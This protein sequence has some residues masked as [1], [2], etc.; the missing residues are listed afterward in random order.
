MWRR[1]ATQETSVVRLH[2]RV[3][4]GPPLV[5]T[6]RRTVMPT[7]EIHMALWAAM[8]DPMVDPERDL[9]P[10]AGAVHVKR[11]GHPLQ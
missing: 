6:S 5:A 9:R 2:R 3:Q 8:V 7:D 11:S 10:V 1:G 4:L